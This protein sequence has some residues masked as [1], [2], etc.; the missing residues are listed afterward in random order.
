MV[1][2]E[3]GIKRNFYGLIAGS[4]ETVVERGGRIRAM[5]PFSHP[6]LLGTF[7]AT[8]IIL[9]ISLW[10]K[11]RRWMYVGVAA[12]ALT[13]FCSASSGPILTLFS[14]LMAVGLWNFRNSVGWI[15]RLV[16]FCMVTLHLVMQAPVWYLMA[17][18]DLAG[19]STGWHRAELISAALNHIGEWW[20]IGTDYTR[21]WI[22]Y[23]V[24]WSA[25]HIDITNHYI[26][27]GVMGGLPLMV[28]FI[29]MLIKSF[30]MLGRKMTVMRRAK[31]PQEFVLWC[32]GSAL[33]AHSFTFLSICYFDQTIVGFGLVLGAVPAVCAAV[34]A[35]KPALKTTPEPQTDPAPGVVNPI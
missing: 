34:R 1:L 9:M 7:G 16:L 14:G 13:V 6:I 17:R 8:S 15:R 20:M 23:G 3:R 21:H 19:G 10:Q 28:C 26:S 25:N 18:I 2:I 11:Y 12:G 22:S 33:F 4:G 5:G 29:L 30:Q 35:R 27:L 31:D 32:V 24:P